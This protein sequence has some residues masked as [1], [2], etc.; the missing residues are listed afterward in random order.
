MTKKDPLSELEK[1][2]TADSIQERLEVKPGEGYLRD[3]VYGAIDGAVTTFAV[4]AGVT[5]A[6]LSSSIIVVLGMAN[7]LGDGFSMA[8][9]NFLATRS[10][11]QQR[12]KARQDEHFH[13]A[14]FPEGEREE[15]RQIFAK[16]GFT[17]EDLEKA[18]TIITSDVKLWIDTM[19]QEELGLTLEGRS[20]WKAALCTFASFFVIGSVPLLAYIFQM[21]AS[22]EISSPFRVSAL[23]TGL[24][25]V[26]VGA[27][28]G[29]FVKQK[30]HWS[31]LETLALGGSASLIAYLIGLWLKGI[32]D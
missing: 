26:A 1:M 15:I 18:V 23:L 6:D 25:F 7:L 21:I 4:V 5:G 12:E 24:A 20:P 27:L 17:G 2:H 30:C 14:H 19:M 9:G 22:V 8:A 11:Q 13:I 29:R 16:K 28:K 32:V 31:A 3:L 10:E